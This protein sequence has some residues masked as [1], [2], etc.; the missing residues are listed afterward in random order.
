MEEERERKRGRHWVEKYGGREGEKG[1]RE[2]RE[3]KRGRGKVG[4]RAGIRGR[5]RKAE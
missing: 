5:K 1:G 2:R 3:R 4:R